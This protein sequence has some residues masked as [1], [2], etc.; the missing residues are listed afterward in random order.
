M[1]G[2]G[3]TEVQLVGKSTPGSTGMETGKSHMKNLTI[4]A[5]LV[6]AAVLGYT[7]AAHAQSGSGKADPVKVDPKHYKVEFENDPPVDRNVGSVPAVFQP[8]S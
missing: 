6:L 1:S 7:V 5:G 2:P 3:L 4:A 8:A